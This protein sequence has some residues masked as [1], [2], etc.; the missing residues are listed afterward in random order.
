MRVRKVN[1]KDTRFFTKT[2][3][4]AKSFL[5]INMGPRKNKPI[6]NV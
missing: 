2:Q 4:V 6:K 3:N 1:D 5:P